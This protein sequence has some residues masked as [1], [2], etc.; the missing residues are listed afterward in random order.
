MV[1]ESIY[2]PMAG[3]VILTGIILIYTQPLLEGILVRKDRGRVPSLPILLSM[4]FSSI[5]LSFGYAA[6]NYYWV[7]FLNFRFNNAQTMSSRG[8]HVINKSYNPGFAIWFLTWC[9][10][11][12]FESYG[13]DTLFFSK[14]Q[15]FPTNK[16]FS[17]AYTR[18]LIPYSFLWARFCKIL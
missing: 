2:D 11:V 7:C 17:A 4:L 9:R 8:M 1:R 15:I 14:A 16:D 13:M 5:V 12:W 18:Q 3:E 6:F 10:Q